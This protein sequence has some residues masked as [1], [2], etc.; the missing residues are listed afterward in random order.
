MSQ[1]ILSWAEAHIWEFESA[2][3]GTRLMYTYNTEIM[4]NYLLIYLY[5][6]EQ[7]VLCELD[8]TQSA[9]KSIYHQELTMYGHPVTVDY[10]QLTVE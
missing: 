5:Y 2:N 9:N 7:K 3:L 6:R 4:Y 1:L 10:S 8:G